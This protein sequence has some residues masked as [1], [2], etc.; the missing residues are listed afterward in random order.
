M[1]STT[2]TKPIIIHSM[3]SVLSP[4]G[5]RRVHDPREVVKIPEIYLIKMPPAYLSSRRCLRALF[6][7]TISR[8]RMALSMASRICSLR[9]GLV[10]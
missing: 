6:C 3:K 1:T 9:K 2:T 4:D 8:Q 7:R 5:G 10:M